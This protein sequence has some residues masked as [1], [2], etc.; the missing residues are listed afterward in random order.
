MMIKA[1]PRSVAARRN[2][3]AAAKALPEVHLQRQVEAPG[4]VSVSYMRQWIAA[5]LTAA[6]VVA[7][8]QSL[9]VRVVGQRESAR[10]NKAYR[11]KLGAT[12]ILSFPSAPISAKAPADLL[13]AW[14]EE[15]GL[16][17]LVLC[18]PVVQAEA[19]EQHKSVVAHTAHLL[20]HGVLHLLGYDHLKPSEA[21]QMEALEVSVLQGLG[22][23]DPY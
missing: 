17:D 7:S 18:W 16:G 4:L 13:A 12:N 22:F 14:H 1:V 9:T 2:L 10:L 20:V 8:E 3:R 23:A 19:A 21:K 5:A 15:L 11:D 6:G